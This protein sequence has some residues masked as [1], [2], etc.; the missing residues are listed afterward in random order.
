MA[1]EEQ[2]RSWIEQCKLLIKQERGKELA[3]LLSLDHLNNNETG[4]V[5]N[6]VSYL[7]SS[8]PSPYSELVWQIMGAA[9]HKYKVD[10][11]FKHLAEA[12]RLLC[13]FL[14]EE[15]AWIVPVLLKLATQLRQVAEK[16]DENSSKDTTVSNKLEEAESLLKRAYSLVVNDRSPTED[17]KKLASLE[18]VN[19]LFRIYFKLNTVHLCRSLIRQVEGPSF[20][21]FELFPL[22]HQVT[23]CFY[24]G[25]LRLF[26]DDFKAT[27]QHLLFAF[28]HCPPSYWKNRRLILMYL[29]PSRMCLGK[30]PTA[31]LIR[32]YR[33]EQY[34][35]K[36]VQCFRVGDVCGIDKAVKE[37]EEF[38][39]RKG[40]YFVLEY[41]KLPTLRN[42]LKRT[43][44][45][46]GTTRLRIA[47]L[48]CAL[49]IVGV[50][51]EVDD[52]E[53]YLANLIYQG[54]IKGYIAHQRGVLV[55]SKLDPFPSLKSIS[56][57]T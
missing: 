17:S 33:L 15:K 57:D 30:L 3:Q 21:S 29:I 14:R 16:A 9:H 41:L 8:I 10:V 6:E 50:E 4:V 31:F 51:M 24:A 39:I 1:W 48:Y 40:V 44:R 55:V 28:R 54:Y 42:L 18:L 45:L 47:D 56:E 22:A 53:C 26:E 23:F 32:K 20:P 43:F 38:F 52:L 7:K 13:G 19:Q 25:R 46:L 11:C 27:E 34:Y 12:M 36:L 49:K 37:Y 2:H 35:G 5:W